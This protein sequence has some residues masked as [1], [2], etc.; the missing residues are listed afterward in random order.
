MRAE[1]FSDALGEI[2]L[3]YV[4][5]AES[6]A[7]SRNLRNIGLIAACACL[8]GVMILAMPYFSSEN[9]LTGNNAGENQSISDGAPLYIG[10]SDDLTEGCAPVTDCGG[11]PG[12][13]EGGISDGYRIVITDRFEEYED[14]TPLYAATVP[15][16]EMDAYVS[17]E[18]GR[19]MHGLTLF[20]TDGETASDAPIWYPVMDDGE[21]SKLYWYAETTNGYSRG[22]VGGNELETALNSLAHLTSEDEP[23]Y[24]VRVDE[25]VFAVIGDKAYLLPDSVFTPEDDTLAEVNFTEDAVVVCIE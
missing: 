22:Y 11:E 9:N 16:E 17:A 14:S 7:K 15:N 19:E 1:F 20:D 4:D 13:S 2:D 21:V 24:L 6:Y 5:E 18:F 23:M 25:M 10:S 12:S 8:A 3:K